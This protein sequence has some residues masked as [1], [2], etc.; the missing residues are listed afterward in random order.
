MNTADK[1]LA[2][3]LR[4]FAGKGFYGTSMDKIAREVGLTKQALIH[5]FRTKEKLYG[6]VLQLI[7]ER[8][9]KVLE[10]ADACRAHASGDGFAVVIEGIHAHMTAHPDDA[11][12]L[13]RELLDNPQR[14]DAAEV[15]YLKPFLDALL[16][17]LS[18]SG[19]WKAANPDRQFTHVF[20]LIGAVH[21]FAV[22]RTTLAHM[23]SP[24]AL[25]GMEQHFADQLV[26]LART[27]PSV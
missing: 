4:Q 17:R 27:P 16:R 7:S 10:D 5:H 22:S 2:A 11:R 24:E 3:A 19:A 8:L 1:F 20:Q 23:Y 18:Q 6:A 26:H 15:W 14:A 13:L 12:L 9:L 25:A 21:Y